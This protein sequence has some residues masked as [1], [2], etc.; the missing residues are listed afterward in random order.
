MD[1]TRFEKLVCVATALIIMIMV[2]YLTWGSGYFKG[3]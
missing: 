2:L 1:K 3:Q